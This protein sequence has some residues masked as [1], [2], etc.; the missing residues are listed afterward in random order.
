[1]LDCAIADMRGAL[2]EGHRFVLTAHLIAHF[3]MDA[4]IR[5]ACLFGSVCIVSL[6]FTLF[7]FFFGT[8]LFSSSI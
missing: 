1:M 8:G 6:L 2:S 4:L 5:N 7:F 3:V